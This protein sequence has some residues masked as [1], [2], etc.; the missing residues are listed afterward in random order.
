MEMNPLNSCDAM[1]GIPPLWTMILDEIIEEQEHMKEESEEEGVASIIF[2]Q[3][4]EPE[5]FHE[6][7]VSNLF[8]NQFRA[9]EEGNS[10]MPIEREMEPTQTLTLENNGELDF[11]NLLDDSNAVKPKPQ[12]MGDMIQKNVKPR[13]KGH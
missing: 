3:S 12:P 11:E 9:P 4:E 1:F 13:K 5:S 7:N 10:I 6:S 8:E 2:N